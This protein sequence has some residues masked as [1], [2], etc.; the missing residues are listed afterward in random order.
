[1]NLTYFYVKFFYITSFNAAAQLLHRNQQLLLLIYT[2]FLFFCFSIKNKIK[3]GGEE[4]KK[5]KPNVD[6]HKKRGKNLLLQSL[7]IKTFCYIIAKTKRGEKP[8]E[9]KLQMQII[10][11]HKREKKLRKSCYRQGKI[12]AKY[13]EW[14]HIGVRITSFPYRCNYILEQRKLI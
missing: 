14:F 5:I 6:K 13:C 8:T 3:K 11:K 10:R 4:G 7:F 1:M 2:F 9:L 12:S